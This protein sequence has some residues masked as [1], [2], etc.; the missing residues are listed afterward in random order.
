[1]DFVPAGGSGSGRALLTAITVLSESEGSDTSA[2]DAPRRQRAM[3][4]AAIVVVGSPLKSSIHSQQR[5][6]KKS[7]IAL[8]SCFDSMA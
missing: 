8:T 3:P 2:I 6:E 5:K 7:S 4:H 1:V